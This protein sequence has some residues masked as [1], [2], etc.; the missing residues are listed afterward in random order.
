MA[1][2]TFILNIIAVILIAA[3]TARTQSQSP[4]VVLDRIVAIVGKE[5]ITQSD[6]DAQVEF[7]AIQ[8]RLDPATTGIQKQVL[9]ALI[10]E[11]LV[12]TR[13]MEDT[14]ITVTDDEVSNELDQT[15]Q[16]RIQ[17][18][19][20]EKKLEDMYGM[21]ISRM[22][23]EFRD[24]MRKNL[25]SQK[26]QQSKFGDIHASRREV[27]AF[28]DK[29]KD[30]LP[31]V[32]EEVEIYHI[33]KAPQM[34]EK[35]KQP[36]RDLIVRILDSIKAGGDFADFAK[37][38]S[39]DR[40][41]AS[42]GGDLGWVKRG[43]FVKEFEEVVF[44]M[45]DSELVGPVETPFG[46]HIIQ[47]LERRGEE[48]H[49]RHILLKLPQDSE[50]VQTTIAFLKSLKDSMAAGQTFY[51]LA[52]KYS[53]DKDSG[54]MGGLIG[55]Y[56]VTQLESSLQDQVKAMKPGDIS[57]PAEVVQGSAKGYHIVYLK[58][59]TTEHAMSL[60]D[61]WSRLEALAT[62]FKKNQEYQDWIAQLHN[63][64]FWESRLQ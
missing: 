22:K 47:L 52:K 11:K 43:E 62:N 9:D 64:I 28:F 1:K 31:K 40:Q 63:E 25:Y 19:G 56:P 60:K 12:L 2:R 51:E 29:Y 54:P 41:S 13:A 39:I 15:L 27:E 26:L 23:R 53:D 42:A 18:A 6:L 44:S 4:G 36:V 20:S 7:Y 33:F 55:R 34:S 35:A 49:S 32:A 30:S 48:V 17:Q 24:E 57:D 3:G 14:N 45:K 61:D 37:R 10:N 50:S 59:R 5:V 46:L 8:N 16:Q 58:D 21:P 38:Y